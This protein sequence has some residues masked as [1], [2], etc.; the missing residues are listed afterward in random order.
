ME[1]AIEGNPNYAAECIEAPAELITFEKLQNLKGISWA[2]YTILVPNDYAGKHLAVF[3]AESQIAENVAHALNLYARAELNSDTNEKGYLGKNRRVKAIRLRGVPSSAIALPAEYFGNPPVGTKFDTVDGLE[4]SRKYEL[5]VREQGSGA[6]N[7]VKKLWRRVDEKYLPMHYDTGQYWRESGK[8]ADDDFL[9]VTQKLHGTSVRIANTLVKRKLSWFERVLQKLGV[10]VKELEYDV[11]GGSRKVIKDPS[12]TTQDHYYGTDLW[13][14]AALDHA[15]LVPKN[16]VV[17]GE[18]IGWVP[19]T[20]SPIQGGYTYQVPVGTYELYVYR[21]AVVTEDGGLYDLS[22]EGVREFC[23]SR[24]LKHVPELWSG[25]KRDFDPTLWTDQRFELKYSTEYMLGVGRIY[26]DK[27]VPLA[28]ESPC[29]EGVVVLR[30]G[31]VPFALK[32]KS[33]VFLEHES[34]AL[35]RAETEGSVVLD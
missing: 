33:P 28:D 30:Q 27:P 35:D 21:V 8:F 3:P 20:N 29:D 17:Y 34:S 19:G 5:T 22:W 31:I 15:E 12:L 24:G 25:L 2:G 6:A 13:T 10:V 7:R 14:K 18:L 9:V 26:R 32:V 4:V 16:V 23:E 11:I 1:Y